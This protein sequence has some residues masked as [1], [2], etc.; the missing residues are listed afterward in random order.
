M[1]CLLDNVLTAEELAEVRKI[2]ESASFEDGKATAGW[3]AVE[4]KHNEQMARKT[5]EAERIKELAL[6]ALKR[7]PTFLAASFYR[8]IRPPL[9]SRYRQEM[10]Y[11]CHVDDPLMGNLVRERTDLALTL[12]ISSPETYEGGELTM[13]SPFGA[14]EIK[15]PAGS[16]VLYP[17]STLH[18]VRP[19]TKG[20]RLAIVTWI[21]SHIRDPQKRELLYE[22]D[23]VRRHL[24]KTQP[25]DPATDLAFKSYANLLRM[26][27]ET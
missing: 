24:H 7:H 18:G 11:G 16:A 10:N 20:E 2:A 22:L 3:R 15:L 6:K 9:I 12:F 4:A 8:R 21:E 27:A 19:V 14:Q 13:D 26:W 25:K 23:Q 1:L 17:A 5:P